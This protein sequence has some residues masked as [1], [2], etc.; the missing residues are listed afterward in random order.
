MK[1]PTSAFL[2]TITSSLTFFYPV[3]SGLGFAI[4]LRLLAEFIQTKPSTHHLYL[5]LTTRGAQKAQATVSR[6]QKHLRHYPS[7]IDRVTF[8]SETLEL[9]SLRSV[10]A[11]STKL[12][13]TVP[14]LDTIVLN[15]GIAGLSGLDWP[16]AI[17]TTT[18]DLV[19]A[20]TWP[21]YKKGRVGDLT[22]RQISS[23]EETQKKGGQ[24]QDAPIIVVEEPPLGEV[25]C[26]NVFGHYM[27]SHLL[28]P[29]LLVAR[30]D[31]GRIIWISSVEVHGGSL[32]AS[33][34]QGLRTSRAYESSKRLTDVLALTSTLPSTRPW[35]STYLSAPT[36]PASSSAQLS[37]SSP[38]EKFT[39]LD[40]S[41]QI[42]MYVAHPGICQ[43]S[44]VPLPWILS[45]AMIIVLYIARWLGSPWHLIWAYSGASAPVWLALTRRSHLDDLEQDAGVGKWGSAT[46][47]WGYDRVMR[48]EVDGWGYGGVVTVNEKKDEIGYRRKGRRPGATDL[49]IE[50]RQEFEEL[51]RICWKQMEDLRERWESILSRC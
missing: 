29:L 10:R 46:D 28:V 38:S 40:P 12:L 23:R 18:T 30:P 42:K 24:K 15:A 26:A 50:A 17:W 11:L 22:Q 47:L 36:L 5:I 1:I 20:V 43:T 27:L 32:I 48:T 49:T 31:P 51:G 6:L 44:I 16:A 25:F 35:T 7:S 3:F 4:C 34:I 13:D 9:T 19:N 39:H 33:D 8:Q 14:K 21:T 41:K 45:L 37:E 2:N